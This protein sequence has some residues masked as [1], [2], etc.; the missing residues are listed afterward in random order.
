[1][2]YFVAALAAAGCLAGAGAGHAADQLYQAT[3]TGHVGA[4][5]FDLDNLFGYGTA[6][7]ALDTKVFTVT[8]IYDPL[9]GN[10]VT[11][12]AGEE[13]RRGGLIPFNNVGPILDIKIGIAGGNT[14]E[15]T[16]EQRSEIR[17]VG[18][19]YQWSFQDVVGGGPS[20]DDLTFNVNIATSGH[21]TDTFTSNAL[22]GGGALHLRSAPGF[23]RGDISL[24]LGAGT[25]T[26]YSP[27]AVPEPA[28]WSL[29]IVGF[30]GVGAMLRQRR[31]A[32]AV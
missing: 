30:G 29:L 4:G 3:F 28:A 9:L 12:P 7:S 27:P 21:L 15:F 6:A 2:R 31:R 24:I 10:V 8:Y 11:L 18:G 20:F 26:T 17:N 16:P 5:A 22:T 19:T 32:L 13:G 25:V 14:L 23:D 1:M